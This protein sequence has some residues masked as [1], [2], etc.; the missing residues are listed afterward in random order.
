M[1]YTL[2]K[3]GA[4]ID[5]ILAKTS[6][7]SSSNLNLSGNVVVGTNLKAATMTIKGNS[8]TL[9][10]NSSADTRIGLLYLGAVATNNVYR[11]GRFYA[12]EYSYNSSSGAT[13]DTYET[14]SF[15]QVTPDLAENGSYQLLTT[16]SPVSIAQGG[17]GETTYKGARDA[18]GL[19]YVLLEANTAVTFTLPTNYKGFLFLAS[20]YAVC[21]G[22]YRVHVNT[23]GIA[24]SPIAMSGE[25]S[26]ATF[27]TSNNTLTVTMSQYTYG[28]LLDVFGTSTVS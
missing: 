23:S 1:A 12:R 8:N 20:A 5:A 19:K 15:P 9:S 2:T 22:I 21:S 4:A 24:Q 13:L 3:T 26:G 10:F 27:T 14:F 28:L 16:K 11:C 7:D 25:A 17:T 6:V 18:F